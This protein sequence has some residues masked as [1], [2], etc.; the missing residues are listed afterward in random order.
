MY[1]ARRAGGHKPQRRKCPRR[2]EPALLDLV[3][4][5]V[6][7]EMGQDPRCL[8]RRARVWGTGSKSTS[9]PCHSSEPRQPQ[10]AVPGINPLPYTCERVGKEKGG[11]GHGVHRLTAAAAQVEEHRQPR[12]L[13]E[14]RP[15]ECLSR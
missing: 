8:E 6:G 12:A 15:F 9:A 13:G 10:K 11:L 5:K 7:Q 3:A 1:L 2:R 4:I 14:G